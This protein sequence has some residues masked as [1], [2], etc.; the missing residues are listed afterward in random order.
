MVARRGESTTDYIA[1]LETE[2]E[3]LRA[4][5]TLLR[6]NREHGNRKSKAQLRKEYC[7]SE[8]DVLFSD[9][10]MSFTAEYLFPRFKFLKKGWTKHDPTKQKGF[11]MLVKRHMPI[12]KGTTFADE[13]DRIIAPA[14]AKKYTDMRC[15]MN[16]LI[17]RTFVCK[18]LAMNCSLQLYYNNRTNILLFRMHPS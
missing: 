10:V 8:D 9:D 12:R 2:L 13:W 3:E 1:R 6:A 14:I 18:C 5:V 15:N 17:R 4:E 7:L 16:N 11:S